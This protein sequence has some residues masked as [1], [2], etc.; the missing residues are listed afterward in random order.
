MRRVGGVSRVRVPYRGGHGDTVGFTCVR[1]TVG[2]RLGHGDTVGCFAV[3]CD[4]E[5]PLLLAVFLLLEV[6]LVE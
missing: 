6:V 5:V 1:D 2:T 4:A 3:L